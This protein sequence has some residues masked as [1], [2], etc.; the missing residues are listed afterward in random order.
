[1]TEQIEVDD[2]LAHYGVPGMR[3]GKRNARPDE[4]SGGSN[5][6]GGVEQ[7]KP[8]MSRKKKIAIAVGIGATV[9]IGAAI[10]ISVM[11]NK[12][13]NNMAISQIASNVSTMRGKSR[14]DMLA[15]AAAMDKAHN[16][17]A[18]KAQVEKTAK[19]VADK[20]GKRAAEAIA[21]SPAKRSLTDKVK[22]AAINKA[23][24]MAYER[25]KEQAMDKAKEFAINKAKSM[26]RP[27]ASVPQKTV[28][29]NPKT[30]LYEEQEGAPAEPARS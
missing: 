2:F 17:P 14:F 10:A 22:E 12:N 27:A 8:K 7:P 18:V 3:W 15:N 5:R 30:G 28:V 19:N 23:K 11:N 16:S 9:A 29:F 13:A 24:D 26:L 21:A 25:A 20:A 6:R 4:R 1:M